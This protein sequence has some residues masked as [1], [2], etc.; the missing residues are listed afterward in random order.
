[1]FGNNSILVGKW[2]F[3]DMRVCEVAI[4][5]GHQLFNTQW[6]TEKKGEKD[7]LFS[8]YYFLESN[9]YRQSFYITH[10]SNVESKVDDLITCEIMAQS[11][12]RE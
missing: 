4:N 6:K 8:T 2:E 7:G 12:R 9:Y 5:S 3:I 10:Q 1:V 11:G